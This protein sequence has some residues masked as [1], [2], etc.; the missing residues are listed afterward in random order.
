MVRPLKILWMG[1]I[2]SLVLFGIC[3]K[4]W[5]GE[6]YT[7]KPG[8]TLNKISE[9][10]GVSVKALREANGLRG[11][12][13]RPKQVLII[14]S[15]SERKSPKKLLGP[16]VNRTSEEMDSY[17]VKKGDT[18]YNISK[19]VGVPIEEIKKLNGLRTSALKIGQILVLSEDEGMLEEGANEEE[20]VA[21]AKQTEREMG[22][23]EASV[24][25]GKWSNLEE[26]NLLV[27]VA[28]TFLGA[29]YKLG[30]STLKGIDCSALVKKIYGI[31]NVELPRTTRE[32][33]KVGKKV[34]KDQL[35]E[36]DLVFFKRRG[37]LAHVGIYV[38]D[39]QFV[40]ASSYSREVKFDH[41][42]APYYSQRFLRGVRV[43]ELEIK[44][45]QS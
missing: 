45:S 31:F 40:H 20:E 24:T 32:Q 13:I 21:E 39:N 3:Q 2:V 38:G 34:E 8:D 17:V 44:E 4:G 43:K 29:P 28:K 33:L 30:G 41:L 6:K 14:P 18:L 12:V 9:S 25:L 1:L 11:D 15:L 35:E 5:P 26:R 27:R 42:D 36:G 37:N 7:V 10:F 22:E 19:K 16:T 23:S